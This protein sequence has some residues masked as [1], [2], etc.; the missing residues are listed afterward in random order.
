MFGKADRALRP[1]FAKALGFVFI[2]SPV[3]LV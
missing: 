3:L 2:Y 1:I